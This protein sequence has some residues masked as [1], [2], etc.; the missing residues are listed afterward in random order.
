MQSLFKYGGSLFFMIHASSAVS[1]FLLNREIYEREDKK[2]ILNKALSN[3]AVFVCTSF[4]YTFIRVPITS[5]P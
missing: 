3:Q 2:I 5:L 4:A 1:M